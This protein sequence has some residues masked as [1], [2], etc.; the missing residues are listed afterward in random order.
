[1]LLKFSECT[2][3]NK[4]VIERVQKRATQMVPELR[5]LSYN[6]RL[7]RDYNIAQ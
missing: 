2:S 6:D 4:E 1:M 3:K 5:W 7:V